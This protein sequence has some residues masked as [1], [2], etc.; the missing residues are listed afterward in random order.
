M[1]GDYIIA[2]DGVKYDGDE[3]NEAVAA[4]KGAAL[5][6]PEGTSVVLTIEKKRRN[7]GYY[8]TERDSKR[9]SVS[10][11]LLGDGIGY[12]RINQFQAKDNNVGGFKGHI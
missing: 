4:M 3:M 7:H 9:E 8:R 2:A 1:P 12:I 10:S 11:K 6:N 5:E